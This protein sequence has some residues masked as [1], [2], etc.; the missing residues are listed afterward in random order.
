M[1]TAY[2]VTTETKNGKSTMS[3][4]QSDLK[5]ARLHLWMK[6][7]TLGSEGYSIELNETANAL[8]AKKGNVTIEIEVG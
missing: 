4:L 1:T 8:K 2:I 7:E 5:G 3:L 6:A